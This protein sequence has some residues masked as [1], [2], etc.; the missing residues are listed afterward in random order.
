[1]NLDG[2]AE[3]LVSRI[4]GRRCLYLANDYL[5]NVGD[6][7]IDLGTV[8][9]LDR[10]GVDYVRCPIG[11]RVRRDVVE[12]SELV[13]M[14]GSGSVGNCCKPVM[15]IRNLS[16][17]W[18]LPRILLPSSAMD[19][20]E[21]LGEC[22]AVFARDRLSQAMLQSGR[23]NQDVELMPDMAHWYVPDEDDLLPA[24]ELA[25]VFLRDDAAA[26]VDL[27]A[28]LSVVDPIRHCSDVSEYCRLAT[29]CE[30]V[31]TNRLHFALAGLAVGRQVVLL[32]TTWHKT[33]A[34]YETWGHELDG[35]GWAWT[36]PEA[37]EV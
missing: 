25:G 30:R 7:M 18:G 22:E 4:A 26:P 33:R 24:Q 5:G 34:Y 16:A 29:V 1:V 32:P 13:L 20:G 15:M 14:F 19:S 2:Y 3:R 9:F 6:R 23:R 31:V 17:S 27:E 8:A 36:V 11:K 28:D 35:L 12:F 37:I 21:Q 10:Y